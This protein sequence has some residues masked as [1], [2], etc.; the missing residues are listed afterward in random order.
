[1]DDA[2]DRAESMQ[3]LEMENL[4]RALA[5]GPSR[6]V[7]RPTIHYTQ[8]A[9]AAEHWPLFREWNFYRREV[10]RWLDEGREGEW[11]LIEGEEVVGFW[12][13]REGMDEF[14]RHHAR[15][16]SVLIRQVLTYEPLFRN[17]YNRLRWRD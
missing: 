6:P 12:K 3:R 11:V 7:Q 15:R 5:R 16:E 13:A 10:G 9:E 17:G 14:L 8:F 1:M 4:L 2:V